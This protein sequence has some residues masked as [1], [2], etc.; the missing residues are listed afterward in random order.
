[1]QIIDLTSEDEQAIQQTAQLLY[2]SFREHH[3]AAWPTP[4][5][6]VQEVRESFAADRI[7]RIAVDDDGSVIGWIGGQPQ[8]GGNVWELHPLVVSEAARGRG[9]GRALVND[10]EAQ[11]RARGGS[12]LWLGTDD[13][14]NQTSLAG[15]DLYP[16]VWEHI[17]NIRNLNHHPYE[18]YQRLGFVIVGVLPDANG[19]GKPDIFM[20]KRISR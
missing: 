16:N 9:V 8:Y 10:L 17:R 7:S 15:A 6:A 19:P 1:M 18:F 20:A 3:P 13:E 11:L 14:N 5:D 12:T 4:G 2:E